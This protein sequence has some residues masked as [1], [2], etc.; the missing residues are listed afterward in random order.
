MKLLLLLLTLLLL[1]PILAQAQVTYIS[2]KIGTGTEADPFRAYPGGTWHDCMDLKTH[3]LC[4]GQSAPV[5]IGVIV[6]SPDASSRLSGAQKILLQVVTGRVVSADTFEDLISAILDTKAI[7]LPPQ[8]DNRQHLKIHGRELWSR[9]APLGAF[10]PAVL[11]NLDV[12]FHLPIVIPTYLVSTAVAWAASFTDDFDCSNATPLDCDQDW[13]T[14]TGAAEILTNQAVLTATSTAAEAR[15][16][17]QVTTTHYEAT[18]DIEAFTRSGSS[19]S[20][21]PMIAKDNSATRTFYTMQVILRSSGELNQFTMNRR[22]AG[23]STELASVTT[24]WIAGDKLTI[25]NNETTDQ[26]TG[27]VNDVIVV[28]P[29]TDGS[30]I[31]GSYGGVRAAGVTGNNPCTVDNFS[32]KDV[33]R[34]AVGP[35]FLN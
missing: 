33:G 28:G 5:A 23:T 20:C 35:F 19:A 27:L 32:I 2:P 17:V 15:A 34:R 14:Y 18:A 10:I 3:F 24:D 13:T 29:T 12:A 25:R 31:T 7:V 11:K 22:D 4:Q 16:E 6:L 30:P 9:P 21:G 1:G 26:V 8:T